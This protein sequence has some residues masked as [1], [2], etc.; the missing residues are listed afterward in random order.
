MTETVPTLFG[1]DMLADPYTRYAEI[2]GPA[3]WNEQ[4]GLWLL[5]R[6]EDVRWALG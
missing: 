6:Y 1:S 4:M 2:R 3:S 5:T